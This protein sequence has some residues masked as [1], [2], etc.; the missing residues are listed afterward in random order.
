MKTWRARTG[1]LN[2][3]LAALLWCSTAAPA[4]EYKIRVVVSGLNRPNGIVIK[5]S[6]T[7]FFTELPTPGIPGSMGGRNTVNRVN[8]ESGTI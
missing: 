5:G 2:L 8:L 4:Q 7:I 1:A 6:G 3:G